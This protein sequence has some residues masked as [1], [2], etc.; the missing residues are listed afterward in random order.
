MS[1]LSPS[2]QYPSFKFASPGDTFKGVVTQEPLDR[3]ALD[4][5]TKQPKFWP[6]GQP[7]IQTRIVARMPDGEE[8]AIYASGRMA[9]AVSRAI[10]AAGATDLEPGGTITVQFTHTEPSKGGGQPAK[11]YEAAYVPPSADDDDVPF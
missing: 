10:G 5:T 7:V 11:Q 1:A 9:R 3:Q 8:R 4:F 6:D 2:A